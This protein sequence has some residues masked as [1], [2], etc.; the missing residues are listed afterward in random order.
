VSLEEGVG[1]GSRGNHINLK[2]G[3]K[4]KYKCF[5]CHKTGH[6]KKNC[7][8]WEGNDDSVQ[9]IVA[10]LDHEDTSAML[11]SCLEEGGVSH[12]GNNN[13]YTS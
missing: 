9:L 7:L 6:F 12:L 10:S 8:G 5:T 11:V 13:T 1:L 3:D 2:V 4:W